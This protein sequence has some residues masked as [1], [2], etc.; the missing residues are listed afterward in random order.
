MDKGSE[1]IAANHTS[2][3]HEPGSREAHHVSGSPQ[4]D[5]RVPTCE[6]GEV[7]GRKEGCL[8]G[9]AQRPSGLRWA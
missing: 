4:K 1:W 8:V 6:M 2:K 3:D 7:E 5:R 9:E